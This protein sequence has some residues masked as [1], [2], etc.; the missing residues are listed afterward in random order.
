MLLR[1]CL[2]VHCSYYTSFY[3]PWY[4]RVITKTTMISF[5]SRLVAL[6]FAFAIRTAVGFVTSPHRSSLSAALVGSPSNAATRPSQN[7]QHQQRQQSSLTKLAM[8]SNDEELRGTDRFKACVPY[9]LPLLDGDQFGHYIYER[10]PPLGR[11]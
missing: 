3:S 6:F 11:M 9:I 2:F 1:A 7:H 4:H 8:W 5:R 10:I